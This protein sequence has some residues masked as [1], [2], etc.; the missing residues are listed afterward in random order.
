MKINK[1]DRYLLE[2]AEI[3]KLKGAC[4]DPM[5]VLVFQLVYVVG[6][7]TSR[8]K[9]KDLELIIGWIPFLINHEQSRDKEEVM[10]MGSLIVG[11]GMSIDNKELYEVVR[12]DEKDIILQC[13]L[14]KRADI[15][16]DKQ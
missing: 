10:L 14:H 9:E 8:T 3:V 12:Q 6:M 11:P 5:N 13:M 4:Y 15:R 16:L 7:P 1:N 2:N